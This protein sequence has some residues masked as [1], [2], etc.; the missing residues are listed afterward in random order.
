MVVAGRLVQYE[1][2]RTKFVVCSGRDCSI[3]GRTTGDLLGE[4]PRECGSA[5]VGQHGGE[6]WEELTVLERN[7]LGSEYPNC[8][9]CG[10]GTAIGWTQ[11]KGCG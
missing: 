6:P 2:L 10:C 5:G 3:L 7:L 11:G 9:C 4:M 1:S 8:P